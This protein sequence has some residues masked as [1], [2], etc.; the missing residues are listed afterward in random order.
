MYIA[1]EV[2]LLHQ[3]NWIDLYPIICGGCCP[4]IIKIGM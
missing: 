1:I 4:R 2:S 3:M